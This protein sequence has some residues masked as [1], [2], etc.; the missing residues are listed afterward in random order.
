MKRL[1]LFM[2]LAIGSFAQG[3]IDT[4]YF[5]SNGLKLGGREYLI[6]KDNDKIDTVKSVLLVTKCDACPSESV[7][8][9]EV[10]QWWRHIVFL[11]IN[12]KAIPKSWMIWQYVP[13]DWDTASMLRT[14]PVW[15]TLNGTYLKSDTV[16]ITTFGDDIKTINL[17]KGRKLKTKNK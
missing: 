16:T 12:K 13:K 7:A 15:T 4:L 17:K 9:Y 3:Q 8:G 10:K 1:L 2:A 14:L 11:D 6:P 5:G